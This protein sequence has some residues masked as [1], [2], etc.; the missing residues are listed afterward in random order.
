M[1]LTGSNLQFAFDRYYDVIGSFCTFTNES[2]FFFLKYELKRV[3]RKHIEVIE[4]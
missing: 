4:I 1:W 2:C 3:R